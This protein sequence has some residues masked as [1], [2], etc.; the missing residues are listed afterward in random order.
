MAGYSATPV[1]R[2]L[3]IVEEMAVGLVAAPDDFA[4]WVGPLPAGAALEPLAGRDTVVDIVVVF[5]TDGDTLRHEFERAM[6]RIPP[7]G[8]IWIAWPK[9][10]SK[11]PTDITE[12]RLREWFLPSGMVD[13][14]VC[15]V[16]EVWSGLRFV[17]RKDHRAA[18]PSSAT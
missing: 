9:R 3:G 2:K 11:V 5:A 10:S 17:V 7:D 1:A 8:A 14:K 16:S 12:D 15:A 6:R 4:D 18:W 13:N